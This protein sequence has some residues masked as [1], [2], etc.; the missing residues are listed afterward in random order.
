[1][2]NTKSTI[3]EKILQFTELY[4]KLL[5]DV[6]GIYE[7]SEEDKNI[8]NKLYEDILTQLLYSPGTLLYFKNPSEQKIAQTV[9]NI[10][11]TNLDTD[12]IFDEITGGGYGG[13]LVNMVSDYIDRAKLLKP[14]FISINPQRTEFKYYFEEAMKAWLYG[15][16][17]ASLI[18]C[19]SII[20]DILKS[21]LEKIDIDLAYN[22]KK[23]DNQIVGVRSVGLSKLIKNALDKKVFSFEDYKKAEQVIKLRNDV[24]HELKSSTYKESY[25]AIINT[26]TLVENL[27]SKQSF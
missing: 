12:E 27:L 10:L 13:L 8:F 26:K 3:Q 17:S 24:V 5:K 14:T 15:V 21:E 4:G 18:L 23:R 1:M 11:Y 2:D 22:L 6:D 7:M 9:I 19:A 16:D 20:E 25:N